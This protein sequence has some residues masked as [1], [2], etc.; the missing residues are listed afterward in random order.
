MLNGSKVS[1][2]FSEAH[3]L[4]ETELGSSVYFVKYRGVSHSQNIWLAEAMVLK[5][6]PKLLSSFKKKL[7]QGK[8]ICD[9]ILCGFFAMQ[10]I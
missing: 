6:A 4:H 3:C 2:S 1:L 7:E 5:E 10:N 8:V 9:C